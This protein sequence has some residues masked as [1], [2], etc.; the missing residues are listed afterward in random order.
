MLGYTHI[1]KGT[2]HD[3]STKP[4][5]YHLRYRYQYCLMG[6]VILAVVVAL[7]VMLKE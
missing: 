3:P 2:T 5:P 1:E 7:L 6:W 4:S